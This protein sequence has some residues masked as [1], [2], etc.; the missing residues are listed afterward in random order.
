MSN[1]PRKHHYVPQTLLVGFTSNGKKTGKL[2]IVDLVRRSTYPSTTE[3]TGKERDYNLIEIQGVDPLLVES[4]LLAGQIEGPAGPALER[5]RRNEIPTEDE[6]VRVLAFMAMQALRSPSRR[7]AFDAFST[8]AMR[9]IMA[10]VT[11]SDEV[12]RDFQDRHA[13]LQ[14]VT[15]EE[16][17]DWAAHTKLAY[18][19]TGH[20]QT[21]LPSFG[22]I[23]D[24]LARRSWTVFMAPEGR[25]QRDASRPSG[26]ATV[27]TQ[28][29]PGHRA[30]PPTQA[31][32][33]P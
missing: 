3:E 25:P 14:D 26:R 18:G 10:L 17:K 32:G 24:L 31:K 20:L 16:A 19:P 8:G 13:E 30:P 1:I 9:T 29:Y 11:Q 6:R 27:S 21:Q 33:E 22:P 15:R 23:L 7:D 28:K 5:L 2:Q 12:Y 4:D